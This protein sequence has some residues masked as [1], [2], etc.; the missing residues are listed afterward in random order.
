MLDFLFPKYDKVNKS[1]GNYISK[2]QIKK[3][4]THDE[5]CYICKK[6][7]FWFKTHSFCKKKYSLEKIVICFYYTKE[8]K[9]YILSFKY[10]H[11]KETIRYISNLMNLFFQSYFYDLNKEKTI[12]TYPDMHWFRKYFVKWYNQSEILAKNLWKLNNIKV[13]NICKKVK[14]TKPQAKI[15]TRDKRL[16]NLKNSFKFNNLDL[17]NIENIIIIDDLITTWATLEEI[18]KCVKK[19]FPKIKIF[20][21]VLARK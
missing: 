1:Y 15:K 18:S 16:L 13:L 12:I 20:W 17:S 3:F 6:E 7:S 9:K 10:Y 5:T 4:K 11:K 14:Y 2:E 21:F 19:F 8:I